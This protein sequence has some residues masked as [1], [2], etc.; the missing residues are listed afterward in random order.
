MVWRRPGHIAFHAAPVAHDACISYW[1]RWDTFQRLYFDVRV[2]QIYMPCLVWLVPGHIA[3]HVATVAHKICISSL[4]FS[5]KKAT[6]LSGSCAM[7]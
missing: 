3:L 7:V 4:S 6:T 2:W 5:Q 1:D